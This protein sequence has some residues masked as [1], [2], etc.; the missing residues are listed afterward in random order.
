MGFLRLVLGVVI[1]CESLGMPEVAFSEVKWQWFLTATWSISTANDLTVTAA[2]AILLFRQSRNVHKRYCFLFF[3]WS[4]VRILP[5]ARRTAA[6]VD[7][8]ILWTIG[9]S[10][11]GF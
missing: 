6:L 4:D 1:V 10:S 3:K 8:L 9:W 11:D 5:H 2:L 7:K